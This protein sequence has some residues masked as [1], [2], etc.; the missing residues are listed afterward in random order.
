MP[1]GYANRLLPALRRVVFVR[2]AADRPDGE[3]LGAFVA[4][5]DADAFAVLVRRHGPMVLGVCRRVVGDI[6][7]ADDAF[8]AVFLVLARRAAAV[9][10][11]GQVGNWLYGVAY[12]TAMKARAVLARRRSREKQVDAMPE[13]P[14]PATTD[15]WTDLHPIIDEE[16]ARLPDKLRLPVVL[17][18]LEGRPQRAVAKHLGIAPATLAARLGVGP[19][20]PGNATLPAGDRAVWWCARR[21]ARRTGVGCVR[22]SWTGRFGGPGCR[23]AIAAGG[24]S[25]ALT[26]LVSAHAVHLC[27]G[28]MRM[29]MLA[30]LKAAGACALLA[31]ALTG[32]LGIGLVPARAGDDPVP[33][34]ASGTATA[35]RP[36]APSH[37]NRS[38]MPPS[39]DGSAST[40][41][42][43]SPHASSWPTLSLTA[44]RTS[45]RGSWTGSSQ[46][47]W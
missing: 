32:G 41:P 14:A 11:R 2:E 22:R 33:P 13:P 30:K 31:L 10:P 7:A 46:P 43:P 28:V 8:Q 6:H 16:L 37:L 12:R 1:T 26:S 24:T 47:T 34:P 29:M 27:E 9:R 15:P 40:S 25:E 21:I 42:A 19:P 20:T 23:D 17:C 44:P 3:L 39:C 35:P 45:A 38:T 18:D 5:R 36:P 4:E